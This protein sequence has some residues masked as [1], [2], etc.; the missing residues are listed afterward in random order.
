MTQPVASGDSSVRTH[1]QKHL[2]QVSFV[3][4]LCLAAHIPAVFGVALAFAT[5][6]WPLTAVA[7]VGGAWSSNLLLVG[8]YESGN[9]GGNCLRRRQYVRCFD[10]CGKRD[11]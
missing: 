1:M 9:D 5:P 6:V 8:S 10:C 4:L 7:V 3:W 2:Q 11:D